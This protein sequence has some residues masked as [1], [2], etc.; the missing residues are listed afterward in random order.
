MFQFT[1]NM[2]SEKIRYFK[3]LLMINDRQLILDLSDPEIKR[4]VKNNT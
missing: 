4:N 1:R 2:N 3:G